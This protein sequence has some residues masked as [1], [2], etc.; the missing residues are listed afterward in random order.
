M[1]I[2]LTTIVRDD[3]DP[4]YKISQ[5]IHSVTEF[6]NKHND[7]YKEWNL[8]SN[9][10][11]C[12]ETSPGKIR[13]IIDLLE[14]LSIK[15]SVFLEPDIGNE[16]TAITIEPMDDITHKKLFKNL[17]LANYEYRSSSSSKRV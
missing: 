5:S 4:A 7:V 10:L 2:K 11:C 9:Y 14:M 16:I 15:Y 1:Q 13:D 3:I 8:N 12:L 17:N 6:V